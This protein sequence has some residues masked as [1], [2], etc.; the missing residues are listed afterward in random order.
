[1]LSSALVGGVLLALIEGVGIAVAHYSADSYRQVSPVERQEIYR[2][3]QKDFYPFGADYAEVS[4]IAIASRRTS[5]SPLA[6]FNSRLIR[7]HC[8]ILRCVIA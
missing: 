4:G 2:Q 6:L 7:R 8:R 3:Q 5:P 1:M